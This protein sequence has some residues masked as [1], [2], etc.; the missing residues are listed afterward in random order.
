MSETTTPPKAAPKKA[1]P[2]K[3]SYGVGPAEAMIS[4]ILPCSSW[5]SPPLTRISKGAAVN[6]EELVCAHIGSDGSLRVHLRG[7]VTV[8]ISEEES[9]AA[10][11]TLCAARG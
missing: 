1:A 10:L 9:A 5:N 4:E 6:R 7:A 11:E 3:P 2:K 8:L